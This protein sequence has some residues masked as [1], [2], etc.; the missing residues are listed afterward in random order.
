MS[1]YSSSFSRL[2]LSS[3]YRE[4][5]NT[6]NATTRWNDSE[7]ATDVLREWKFSGGVQIKEADV[8]QPCTECSKCKEGYEPHTWR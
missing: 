6:K 3:R 5:A 7:D 2:N 1:G 8:G 4:P